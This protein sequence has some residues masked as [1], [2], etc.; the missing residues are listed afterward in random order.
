M[1]FTDYKGLD[2]EVGMQNYSSDNR[3]LDMGVDRGLYPNS[4]TYTFGI[5][6]TF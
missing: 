3:N 2:P 4:R 5:G 1:T 6:V